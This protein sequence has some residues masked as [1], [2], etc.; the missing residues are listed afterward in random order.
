MLDEKS[1]PHTG[2]AELHCQQG[3]TVP[4][5]DDLPTINTQDR[6]LAVTYEDFPEAVSSSLPEVR[7]CDDVLPEVRYESFPEVRE[8]SFPEVAPNRKTWW[9]KHF[10][11]VVLAAAIVV[12]AVIGGTVGAKRHRYKTQQQL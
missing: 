10:L 6:H 12:G 1:E 11:R 5:E 2:L 8:E 3:E 9:K 7:P 4:Q